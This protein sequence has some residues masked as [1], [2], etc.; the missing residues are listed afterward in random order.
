MLDWL[1]LAMV[2]FCRSSEVRA[3]AELSPYAEDPE[4]VAILNAP[5]IGAILSPR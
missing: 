2:F 1:E 5:E 4:L 3:A